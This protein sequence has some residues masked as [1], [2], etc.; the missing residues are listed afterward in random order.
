MHISNTLHNI[1]DREHMSQ[2][3]DEKEEKKQEESADK[4][5]EV[6]VEIDRILDGLSNKKSLSQ[7]STGCLV[8]W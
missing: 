3:R 1:T 2:K 5:L 6:N 7:T 4:K 8:I